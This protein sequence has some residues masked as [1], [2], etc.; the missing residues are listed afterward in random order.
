MFVNKTNP[1]LCEN[2]SALHL[3]LLD[4]GHAVVDENWRGKSIAPTF[5]R[6]YFVLA[7][8]VTITSLQDG[9]SLTV[10]AGNSMLLPAGYS[11][12]HSTKGEMEQ[13][14]F[15][16]KLCCQDEL[17]LLRACPMPIC[18][19]LSP[20]AFA[21]AERIA[22]GGSLA[23]C[24][25]IKCLAMETLLSILKAGGITLQARRYTQQ[26]RLAMEYISAH[27]SLQLSLADIADHA[28]LAPSTLTRNFKRETGMSV[29]QYIDELL[30]SQ[31]ARLLLE[32]ENTI[33]EISETLGF[34]DQF[35]FARKFK[36][37]F[38]MPPSDYRKMTVI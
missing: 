17:D 11:F 21:C 30:F 38:G 8:E 6:I 1:T 5:S 29:S 12:R 4:L 28:F 32:K 22:E 23:D 26:V 18:A 31:A 35:Y 20:R 19:P 9:Q 37:R 27:L 15:H 34:C 36:A 7:G 25:E 3:H 13:I 10:P 33:Q 14:Y 16:V 24:L 2:I